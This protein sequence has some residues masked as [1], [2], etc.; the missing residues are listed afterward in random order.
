[1][2]PEARCRAARQC[3]EGSQSRNRLSGSTHA[4]GFCFLVLQADWEGDLIA[5]GRAHTHRRENWPMK[6]STVA[7]RRSHMK[8]NQSLSPRLGLLILRSEEHT[9]ELQSP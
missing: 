1:M 3:L 5:P 6:W 2:N 8:S 4:A 9:S 7:N